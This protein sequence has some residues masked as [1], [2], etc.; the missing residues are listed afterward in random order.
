MVRQS[1]V[2][3]LGAHPHDR[4]DRPARRAHGHPPR[5][6]RR[7]DRR[8]SGGVTRRYARALERV[9]RYGA[10]SV[11]RQTIVLV[12]HLAGGALLGLFAGILVPLGVALVVGDPTVDTISP[13]GMYIGPVI[14]AMVGGSIA[15]RRLRG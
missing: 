2:S 9:T 8:P 14:G 15:V 3:A 13:Y 10:S 1:G 7:R 11:F 6:H 12:G 5:T 4:G